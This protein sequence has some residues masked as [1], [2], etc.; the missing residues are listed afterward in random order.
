MNPSKQLLVVEDDDAVRTTV[1]MVLE[2]EGY[3]VDAVPST[4]VALE[5]LRTRAYPIVLSD[6]Y[7]D[8][9]TGLDI[10]RAAK[11]SNPACVVILMT[12]RGSIET[13]KEATVN[14]AFEYLAKPFEIDQLLHV[15]SRA[16]ASLQAVSGADGEVDIDDL[17]ESEMI[18]SSA[19]MID[20]YKQVV[21]AAPTDA[22]VLIEGETGTGK[23]LVARM[24]HRMSKRSAMPFVPVDCGAIAP[25]L[26]EGELFGALKGSYTGADRDRMGVLES[27]DRGTVFLDEIG[28]ID[29][30]FQLKLL[31]FLE[32]REIR[33]IGA[34]RAKKIDVRVVAATNKDVP[35]MVEEKRFREDLWFRLNVVRLTL[36]PLCERTGDIALLSHHFLKKYN[37]RYSQNT[38]L[39][40]SGLKALEV[41]SWPGNVRQLQHMIER[42]AILAPSSRVDDAAVKEAIEK[43]DGKESGG[44]TLAETEAEQIRRVLAACNGNKSR[45]ARILGIE[46]KTLYRKLDRMGLG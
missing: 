39:L 29:L 43:M 13:V 1:V 45:A 28:D 11:S 41:Y 36:P 12:G 42:L 37:V 5:L 6:I 9:K 16:E 20:V 17:P 23:E 14:G 7:L 21:R 34:P 35:K 15:L 33:Q 24:V 2:Q 10:L 26:L 31:R 3:R 22:T 40:E 19:G 38:K 27:A 46:R 4:R 44:E 8:E 18:G 32:E 30:G 25:S